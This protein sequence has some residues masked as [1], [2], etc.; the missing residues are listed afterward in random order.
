MAL[1]TAPGAASF[2]IT[3]G[4]GKIDLSEELAEIIRPDNN[5]LLSR[6]GVG[7]FQ[8]TQ[9]THRWNEDSLNPNTA[10]LSGAINNAVTTVNVTAGQGVRFKIGSLFKFD[11]QGKTEVCRV[12]AIATDALTVERGYGS[13]SGEAHADAVV[14]MIIAHTKQDGWK[15]AE[16]D[17]TKERKTV[18]NF[19]SVMGYGIAITRRRQAID[20]AGI[21]SEFAHQTAYRL[22]EFMRQLDS[23]LINSIK[24]ASEGSDTDYSSMGGLI[25]YVSAAGGNIDSVAGAITTG[26]VNALVQ[27]IWDKGG[28]V[29]GGRLALICGGKQKRSISA[30]DQAYRRLDFDSRVAGFVVERYLSDL[31]FELEVIV[32]PWVPADTV[33]VGDLN[34]VKVGPLVTDAVALEDLAKVGR[35]IEA[36]VSGSYTA[37]VRN[38]LEAWGIISNLS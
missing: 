8:A 22:K 13:T 16:E 11:E 32:D 35:L 2:D 33:L 19:L 14:I 6:V 25:E 28:F 31:G 12:T 34:R 1:A 23:S 36:M 9:L 17:W 37:E 38:A 3:A 5:A 24:S 26:K 7:G 4:S 27:L 29:A 18:T 15:P 20:H 21:A 30:F 10:T